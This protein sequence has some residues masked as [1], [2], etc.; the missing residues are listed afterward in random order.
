MLQ[1]MI[2]KGYFLARRNTV[3]QLNSFCSRVSSAMRKLYLRACDKAMLSLY[4]SE[5]MEWKCKSVT[6][7]VGFLHR[8]VESLPSAPMW[9][10]VSRK[11]IS[12][13]ECSMVNL[14]V[15]WSMFMK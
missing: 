13:L 2:S 15:G 7:S 4:L 1:V 8:A 6:Q 5:W 11:D 12:W 9:I 10:F 3:R 14:I